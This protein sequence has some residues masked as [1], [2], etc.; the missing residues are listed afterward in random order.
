M[1]TEK[2]NVAPAGR[3]KCDWNGKRTLPEVV[4][5]HYENGRL[6]YERARCR[7]CGGVAWEL[8]QAPNN[9]L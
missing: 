4:A 3:C 6:V 7:V 1:T 9:G 8:G 2:T 5:K